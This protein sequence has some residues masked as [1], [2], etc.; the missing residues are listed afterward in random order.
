MMKAKIINNVFLIQG[1]LYIIKQND[2]FQLFVLDNNYTLIKDYRTVNNG[3]YCI[4][5]NDAFNIVFFVQEDDTNFVNFICSKTP[6][7]YL[8]P[9]NFKKFKKFINYEKQEKFTES[10]GLFIR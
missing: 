6:D 2:E 4:I 5:A 1:L 7:I 10:S 3:R 9:L 8:T